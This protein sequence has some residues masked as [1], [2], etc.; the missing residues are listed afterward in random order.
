MPDPA[1]PG[2]FMA[3]ATI[4]IPATATGS[5][6]A[7]IE[8]KPAVDVN[9]DGALERLPVVSVGKAF[10]ITDP[11]PVPYRQVVDVTKCN[12]CHK[13]LSLHGDSRTGN[14]ELCATCH[15]PNATD[16]GRRVAGSNCEAVTGTLDDQT[17]DLKYMIHA[18]HAGAAGVGFKVC[19]FNNT[20]Y[21]F[22]T[23]VF[24]GKINN[25]E[26]CHLAGTYYPPN[27]S[28]AIATTIDAG[29]DRSTPLGDVAMS[30]AAS[31]CSACHADTTARNHIQQNGGS[32][33]AVKAADSTT[34]GAPIE[35]CDNCHGP[36]KPV[37]VKV[38]HGVD[39]FQFN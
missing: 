37:D 38:E 35:T 11:T 19:G 36:G 3:T 9:G 33:N 12:D 7:L 20:G 32:F 21:D 1:F 39:Q 14:T 5:G 16:I 15:N 34:P 23:V 6:E 24:P 29:P 27:S 8:G 22:S 25:C 30:P 2:G 31:A 10:S 4:P 18:I 26:G 17:I 28:I 13:E